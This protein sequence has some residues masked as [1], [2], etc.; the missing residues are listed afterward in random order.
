MTTVKYLNCRQLPVLKNLSVIERRPLLGASL[1]KIVAF[2]TKHFIRYSRHV[3][4]LGCQLL[5]G[6]T[7]LSFLYTFLYVKTM[8]NAKMV[9]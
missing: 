7:V 3:R 5:G 2:G 6:F 1:T 8:F 9:F 4:Y